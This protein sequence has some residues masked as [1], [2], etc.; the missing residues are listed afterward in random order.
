[1]HGSNDIGAVVADIGTHSTR[2]G[3][4]GDDM[5]KAYFPTVCHLRHIIS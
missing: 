3:F 2:I 1:M 4:A 5:P